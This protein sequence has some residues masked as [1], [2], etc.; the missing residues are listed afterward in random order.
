MEQRVGYKTGLASPSTP[1]VESP[2]QRRQ[3]RKAAAASEHHRPVVALDVP[4]SAATCT[5]P[6]EEVVRIAVFTAPAYPDTYLSTAALFDPPLGQRTNVV[7]RP[8][9]RLHMAAA[10]ACLGGAA[11]TSRLWPPCSTEGRSLTPG[12]RYPL[13]SP[14]NV[15]VLRRNNMQYQRGCADIWV[16]G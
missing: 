6:G 14:R 10:R 15:R 16:N 9:A 5:A 3:Q 13:G 1:P 12:W 11:S 8:H 7:G 4:S 2:A